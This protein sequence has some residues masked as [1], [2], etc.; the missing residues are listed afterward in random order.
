M[1]NCEISITRQKQVL[2][3]GLTNEKLIFL[4]FLKQFKN[5]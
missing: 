1:E 5:I 4:D 2:K 3:N